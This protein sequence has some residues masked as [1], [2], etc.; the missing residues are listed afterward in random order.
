M[1][2][3]KLASEKD[4]P[5]FYLCTGV[6][7]KIL[8]LCSRSIV[9]QPVFVKALL[10]CFYLDPPEEADFAGH[11]LNCT[12][13]EAKAFKDS[14]KQLDND[15]RN[16]IIDRFKTNV[17]PLLDENRIDNVILALCKLIENDSTIKGG[18]IVG[19]IEGT[20]KADLL[21]ITRF[22]FAEFVVGILLYTLQNTKNMTGRK[23]SQRTDAS[24]IES[25][26]SSEPWFT[27]SWHLQAGDLGAVIAYAKK[28]QALNGL[29]DFLKLNHSIDFFCIFGG[30][31]TMLIDD[32]TCSLFSRWL[33]VNNN[34]RLYLCYEDGEAAKARAMFIDPNNIKRDQLPSDPYERMMAKADACSKA[35]EKFPQNVRDRVGLIPIVKPLYHHTMV[36]G[37]DVYWNNLTANRSTENTTYKAMYTPTGFKTKREQLEYIIRILST[38]TDDNSKLLT[39]VLCEKINALPKS[40]NT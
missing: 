9:T 30:V 6:C 35:I 8:F 32:E 12:K 11:L 21:A 38:N 24:F 10:S 23:C 28:H 27:W 40:S 19:E 17:K 33:S 20:R 1:P 4:T 3:Q 25:F 18:T 39:S 37:D 16:D 5:E 26:S 22:Y 34:A 29:L 14:V 36:V 15:K 13:N 2:K 31:A 7:A